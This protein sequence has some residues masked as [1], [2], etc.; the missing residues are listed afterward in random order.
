MPH[1]HT[2]CVYNDAI[3][4]ESKL[5]V[6]YRPISNFQGEDT[7][8]YKM[9]DGLGGTNEATVRLFVSEVNETILETLALED[10]GGNVKINRSCK[11]SG[12]NA[13]HKNSEEGVCGNPFVNINSKYRSLS[14]NGYNLENPSYDASAFTMLLRHSKPA[15]SDGY[16]EP[17]GPD[18]PSTRH[19]SNILFT[20]KK[21]I[22]DEN[23]LND[24]SVHMGQFIA[25]DMSFVTPLAD[26]TAQDN[27]AIHIPKGDV[28][29][30]PNSTGIATMRFR[31]SGGK[32][33]T[34]KVSQTPR[35]QVNKVSGWLD[36]SV[37]YGAAVDRSNAMRTKSRGALKSNYLNDEEQL[38]FNTK[39]LPN[40][41]LLGR[42]R[43]SLVVSGDNRVNVQPGLL[44]FH[45]IWAREHNRVAHEIA[46]KY[47]TM[48]D[49]SIFQNARRSTIATYQSTL[50]Y[51]W[52]PLVIGEKMFN[53]E[54]GPYTKYDPNTDPRISNEFTTV[55]FR[56]G[57]SQASDFLARLDEHFEEIEHGHL[58]LKNTYFTPQRVLNEG[59]IDPIVLGMLRKRCQAIDTVA[60]D[61]LRNHL[62][63]TST[64]GF[65]LVALNIQRG[66]D[67]GITDYNSLREAYGLKRYERFE[68]ISNDLEIVEKLKDL[69]KNNISN[70]DAFVG[71]LAENHM[72]GASIGE[73]FGIIVADQFKRS[74]NGDVH[75]FEN[76]LAKDGSDNDDNGDNNVE[77]N[78]SYYQNKRMIDVLRHNTHMGDDLKVV[79]VVGGSPSAYRIGNL[80]GAC[81]KYV[82]ICKHK[83][84][85][86]VEKTLRDEVLERYQRAVD[87]FNERA[88]SAGNIIEEA[89]KRGISGEKLLS[90]IEDKYPYSKPE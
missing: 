74:R 56:F 32:E 50:M 5:H 18:R 53:E 31:R 13:D 19:I 20:Q 49:E 72:I 17:A 83:E 86:V 77:F 71:G 9:T 14:G 84:G 88:D 24:L 46:T 67:H 89:E 63:G 61:G 33:G 70:I 11:D 25:H 12:G 35:Q 29:F 10:K 90:H 8:T 85:E 54:I 55:A 52:L 81:P 66:R 87:Y 69:Y 68:E 37:V 43:E 58:H 26:F 1:R 40:L 60:A 39:G 22:F 3:I 57:H 80:N 48:D 4:S 30:D 16:E 21:Q 44:A 42:E 65:D 7:F 34:G 75:W 82:E 64:S 27:F 38:M 41:N 59:G 51:E 79:G 23:G 62:F 15:Y 36:L 47:P 45:T 78:I 76:P 6:Q 2:A 73:L 28:T